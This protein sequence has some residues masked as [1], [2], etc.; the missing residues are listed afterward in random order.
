[1][2]VLIRVFW[3]TVQIRVSPMLSPSPVGA[4]GTL[5]LFHLEDNSIERLGWIGA[6]S[7]FT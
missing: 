4:I 5:E 2:A 3:C 6:E 7:P 1:M